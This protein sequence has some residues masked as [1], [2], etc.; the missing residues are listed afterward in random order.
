MQFIRRYLKPGGMVYISYNCLTGWSAN[1]PVREL[2]YS[3]FNYSN[4]NTDTL[5]QVKESLEFS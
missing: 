2:F 4:K 5:Q 1:M 3:H